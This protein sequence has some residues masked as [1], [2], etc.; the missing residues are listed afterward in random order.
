M[1][2]LGSYKTLV[3]THKIT[4]YHISEDHIQTLL[5]VHPTIAMTILPTREVFTESVLKY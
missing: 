1:E 2:I 5:A 3:I 4:W